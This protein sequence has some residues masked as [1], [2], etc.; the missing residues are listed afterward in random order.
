MLN[1]VDLKIKDEIEKIA[2]DYLTTKP[3]NYGPLQTLLK[4][5]YREILFEM[6]FQ[7]FG[8]IKN[9]QLLKFMVIKCHK[10][11]IE[12]RTKQDPE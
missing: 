7:T 2:C 9:V 5:A 1:E 3:I 4:G 10:Q 8:K 11:L 6:K 12:V